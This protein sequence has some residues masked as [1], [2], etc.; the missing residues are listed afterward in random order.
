MYVVFFVAN[1]FLTSFRIIILP[2]LSNKFPILVSIASLFGF[3]RIWEFILILGDSLEKKLPLA[4]HPNKRI[5]IQIL[6]T[7]SLAT[8]IGYILIE[9]SVNFLNVKIP[10]ILKSFG[11]LLY[12]LLSVVMNLIYFGTKYFFN[13]K[14]D[15][16]KLANMQR[17]Q[18]LV[19]YNALRNQLNPHF[20]FNALTSLNSLIFENQQLASDFLQQLSKSIDTFCKIKKDKLFRY[21]RNLILFPI[22]YPF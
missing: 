4:F 3:W 12:F 19:K 2:D 20:L 18:T 1:L 17:E 10:N 6:A 7:Y 22:I 9:S 14:H 21:R 5:I 13:W 15:L 8:V 16:V 11:Y